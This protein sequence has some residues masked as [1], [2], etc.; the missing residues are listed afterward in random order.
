MDKHYHDHEQDERDYYERSFTRRYEY[1]WWVFRWMIKL[2]IPMLLLSWLFF[3]CSSAQPIATEST[4]TVIQVDG[5]RVLVTFK[6][7]NKNYADQGMN[8]F[9]IPGHSYR[10]GDRYPDPEK[11]PN[12]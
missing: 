9:Y 2:I 10:E 7:V 4:G 1:A 11:D 5:D 3:G 12:L 8:W 6:V